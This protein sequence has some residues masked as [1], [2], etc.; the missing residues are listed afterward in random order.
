MRILL[1][2]NVDAGDGH[3]GR[4][5][6]VR[7]IRDA[8]HTVDYFS[9]DEDAWRDAI[10]AGGVDAVA[11]AGGDGTVSKVARA[12]AGTGL[13]IAVI[14]MGT[15]NNIAAALDLP[16][17][18]IPKLVAGWARGQRRPFDLGVVDPGKPSRFIESVGV[19]LLSDSIAEIAEGAAGYVDQLSD[20]TDRLE[21]AIDVL[22]QELGRM[23]PVHVELSLDGRAVSGHYLLVEVLNFG[24][25]GANLRLARDAHPADGMFDVVLVDEGQRRQF[26]DDL[27]RYRSDPSNARILPTYRARR[28]TL[29]CGPCRLHV[30]DK[31]RRRDNGQRHTLELSVEPRA[32]TFLI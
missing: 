9:A 15:A 6:L 18:S 24:V 26:M 3:F 19:G 11:A 8:G 28:V 20:A 31:I 32:L 10:A 25:A 14:P 4:Q 7:L 22:R 12:S 17:S 1:V 2:H 27:P 23:E 5:S 29:S 30:D 13:P 16:Q 21:A